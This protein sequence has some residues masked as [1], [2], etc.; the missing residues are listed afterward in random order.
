MHVITNL[1]LEQIMLKKIRGQVLSRKN[2][3]LNKAIISIQGNTQKSLIFILLN[4]SYCLLNLFD[5]KI[6]LIIRLS[7]LNKS[8]YPVY[9]RAHGHAVN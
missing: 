5:A 4:Q 2:L 7:V 3:H 1:L 8:S 6:R 9:C